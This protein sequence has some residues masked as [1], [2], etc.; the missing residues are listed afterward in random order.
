MQP[1][2][3]ETTETAGSP[4][5][6]AGTARAP[7]RR[8]TAPWWRRP[9]VLPLAVVCAAFL[10]FSLPPYLTFD[11]AQSRVAPR[12]DV[13]WH[14]P[15]LVGHILLGSV[16]LAASCLQVWPWLRRRR[17]AVHRWSGRVY[18]A[19]ALPTALMALAIAPLGAMGLAQQTGN[20]F[21]ALLWFG[22]T[23]AGY[24]AARGRRFADHR[25]WM[26]RSFALAWSIV[27]NRVWLVACLAMAAPAL[28]TVYGGDEDL[29]LQAAA[30]ASVWLSWVAN[31]LIAEWWL[32]R[33]RTGG[34][35]RGPVGGYRTGRTVNWP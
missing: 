29:M 22:C 14:Y 2:P 34:R 10:A 8:A 18:V 27:T 23:L 9:W 31:L 32:R 28:D 12:A 21:S 3:E 19:A 26:V 17:P 5:P 16:V 13:A 6:T 20:A 33:T 24:R 25:E 15:V 30:G 1:T 4:T 11:P 7:R 35:T